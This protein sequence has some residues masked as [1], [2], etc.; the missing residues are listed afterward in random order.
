MGTSTYLFF[1]T[2]KN[3]STLLGI[4]TVVY[5]IYALVTNIIASN[6]NT[7]GGSYTVDYLSISLS[8]KES[9]PTDQNKLYF[10]IQA[11]LGVA[12]IVLWILFFFINRHKEYQ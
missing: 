11:W 4:L 7:L 9:N 12:T 8:A 1:M 3:L 6:S 2:F 10:Y 5:S